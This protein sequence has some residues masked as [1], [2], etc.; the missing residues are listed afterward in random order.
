MGNTLA[1]DIQK[2]FNL[3]RVD[4]QNSPEYKYMVFLEE[5]KLWI[6]RNA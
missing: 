3:Q 4:D 6:P 5:K 1:Q 2:N